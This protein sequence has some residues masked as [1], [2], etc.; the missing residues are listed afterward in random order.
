MG[1]DVDNYFAEKTDGNTIL[2]YRGNINPDLIN[3][4]LDTVEDK[5]VLGNENS[6]LRK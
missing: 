2:F 6:K 1:F 5:L 4:I 3:Q